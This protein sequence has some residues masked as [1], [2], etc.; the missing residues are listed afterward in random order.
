MFLIHEPDCKSQNDPDL[1]TLLH[2]EVPHQ[3]DRH[4]RNGEVDDASKRFDSDPSVDL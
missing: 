4:A 3:Q 2:L 1:V